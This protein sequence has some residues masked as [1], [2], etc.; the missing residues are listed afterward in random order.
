[1]KPFWKTFTLRSTQARRTDVRNT[2]MEKRGHWHLIPD[3]FLD[4]IQNFI[5][6]EEVR[7]IMSAQKKQEQGTTVLGK[8]VAPNKNAASS[9]PNTLEGLPTTSFADAE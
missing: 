2:V 8:D 5:K 1:M 9:S 6:T 4:D 3:A 7:S